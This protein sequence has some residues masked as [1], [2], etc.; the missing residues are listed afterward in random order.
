MDRHKLR[1]FRRG[2]CVRCRQPRDSAGQTCAGCRAMKQLE[3]K[4]YWLLV[5]ALGMCIR[6]GGPRRYRFSENFCKACARAHRER[7]AR[8]RMG[9]RE[10]LSLK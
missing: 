10:N 9:T 5:R 8:Y 6:C 2:Q 4:L 7:T 1:R 3:T